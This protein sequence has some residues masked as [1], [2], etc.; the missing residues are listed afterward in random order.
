MKAEKRVKILK[1][2]NFT[3]LACGK[4]NKLTID[5]IIPKSMKGG[6]NAM[7]NYQ[8]LCFDC[9]Q[10][11]ADKVICYTDRKNACKHLRK[12]G[13]S[14]IAIGKVLKTKY[15]LVQKVRTTIEK[16]TFFKKKKNGWGDNPK[17]TAQ[18]KKMEER[19]KNL[20]AIKRLKEVTKKLAVKNLAFG[21]PEQLFSVIYKN[22]QEGWHLKDGFYYNQGKFRQTLTKPIN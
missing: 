1:R 18:V 13:Y 20:E 22:R 10:E 11:K 9:N 12:Y 17:V 7:R 15:P 3:C 14:D 19:A 5:H 16:I 4:R 8:T 6:T 21:E 2:D